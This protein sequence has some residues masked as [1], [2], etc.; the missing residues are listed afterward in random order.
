M[1]GAADQRKKP[2]SA[3][4]HY[5]GSGLLSTMQTNGVLTREKNR[6]LE[7]LVAEL[8][9]NRIVGHLRQAAQ[10]TVDP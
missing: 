6:V 9:E 5:R 4:T 7:R 1:Y 8:T 3:E 2:Y 10:Y